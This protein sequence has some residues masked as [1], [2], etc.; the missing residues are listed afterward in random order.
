MNL[1]EY[2]TG[3]SEAGVGK[4]VYVHVAFDCT[5]D[6]RILP[7]LFQIQELFNSIGIGFDTG[8]G[9]GVR[10]WE[11]DWSL[12]GPVKVTLSSVQTPPNNES[13]GVD[14]GNYAKDSD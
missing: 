1:D 2:A 8:Y 5:G 7:V 3:I 14:G 6:K 13:D 10:D 11:W 9:D 12:R 4:N